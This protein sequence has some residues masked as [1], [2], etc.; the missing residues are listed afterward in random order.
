MSGAFVSVQQRN[1]FA[2]R[3]KLRALRASLTRRVCS[4][5]VKSLG[6]EAQAVKNG[7]EAIAALGES[8]RD[9]LLTDWHMPIMDG[10]DLIRQVRADDKMRQMRVILI[11]SDCALDSVVKA[12]EA[13]ADDLVMKPINVPNLAERLQEFMA[14]HGQ[15]N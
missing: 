7:A 1:Y 11:T 8:S 14:S 10:M 6:W 15:N 5:A 9:L 13:G 4:R 3:A 2:H 12:L